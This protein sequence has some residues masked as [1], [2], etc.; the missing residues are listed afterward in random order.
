M[1]NYIIPFLILTALPIGCYAQDYLK[2]AKEYQQK[3]KDAEVISL[4][5]DVVFELSKDAK[6]M[7][8]VSITSAHKLLSLRYNYTFYQTE[9]YDQNS[10]IEKFYGQSSLNQKV[11]DV[12]KKC[13]TYTSAGLFFDDSKFC[14]HELRLKELGERW[15]M[16]SVKKIF[17]A[18]YLT[19]V[20]FQQKH[21]IAEKKIKFVIPKDIEVEL[22]EF[23][24]QQYGITRTERKEGT[25]T[26]VEFS[27]SNLPAFQNEEYARGHQ[28]NQ[29]HILVLVKT[30]TLNEKKI[31]FLASVNDLYKWYSE[32]TRQL[33]PNKNILTPIVNSLIQDKPTDEDK[34]KAIYYWIQD[35]IR[36][37]AFEDGIAGFKPDEAHEVFEKRYGDCKG[38]A[39]LT[40]EMLKIAGYDAR[41]TWIGTKRILYDQSIPSL[42]I[43]N[44]MICTVFLK[45]KKYFL[46][47]T[48]KYMPLGENADRIQNR[49]VMIEN[50]DQCIIEKIDASDKSRDIDYRHYKVM[51]DGDNLEGKL[52][53]Q[54]KG[55]AK[56]NFLYGYHFT[57]R[58]KQNDFVNNFVGSGNTNVKA[59]EVKYSSLEERSGPLEID[60]DFTFEKSVTNFK[61]EYYVDIDL[62]KSFKDFI[63]KDG[64]QSDIDF[65]EKLNKRTTVELQIPPDFVVEHIPVNFSITKPEFSFSLQYKKVDNKILYISEVLVPNGIITRSNFSDWNDAVKALTHAYE[66]QLV[67]KKSE[68]ASR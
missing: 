38:M 20:Y 36:Y 5:S 44:H 9:V 46:D 35:N 3:N 2:M 10:K 21:P 52:T 11:T 66:N 50:G 25:N 65:G 18:K 47:P 31:N 54:L 7:A 23:N 19:T 45:G 59:S 29:P 42:A 49:M 6:T 22:R 37:I 33:Q 40:K 24:C 55:E 43:N 64:R 28:Y 60:G 63:I 17:D 53:I 57:K 30:V 27:A 39:N 48:E 13:G 4:A 61:N 15:D 32:L 41:L 14:T 12:S 56:K 67:L 68:R 16:T 8:K 62:A 34:I 51:L 26:I 1:K 58:E